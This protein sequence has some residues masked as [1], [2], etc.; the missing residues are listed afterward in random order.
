MSNL[1]T[2]SW[3]AASTNTASV[4]AVGNYTAGVLPLKGN[5]PFVFSG[6]SI[7]RNLSFTNGTAA[8]VIITGL[9]SPVTAP[10]SPQNPNP[11]ILFPQQVTETLVLTGAGGTQQSRNIYQQVQS[12]SISTAIN[13]FSVGFGSMGIMGY[14]FMDLNRDFFQATI[15]TQVTLGTS[16]LAYQGYYTLDPIWKPSPTTGQW[17]P[18]PNGGASIVP[19][20]IPNMGSAAPA[21]SQFALIPY[22]CVAVWLAVWNDSLT[23]NSGDT[24][25]LSV[26]Q[27]GKP[28]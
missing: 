23:T 25:Y 10:V 16:D 12:I 6:N 11:S 2:S 24:L 19:W 9:G 1:Y 7:C 5:T 18:G 4:V 3:L 8:T 13:N 17:I 14:Y 20:E 22:P 26:L 27:Q 28:T 15:Q 21:T